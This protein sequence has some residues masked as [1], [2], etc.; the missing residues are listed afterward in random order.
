MGG[1]KLPRGGRVLAWTM[2]FVP[3]ER[4]QTTVVVPSGATASCGRYG[5]WPAVERSTGVLK[6]PPG[7]RVLAWTMLLV[8]LERYQTTVVVPSGATATWG[9][10]A[11][12]PAAVMSPIRGTAKRRHLRERRESCSIAMHS[13]LEE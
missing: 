6:L 7:G 13:T 10:V 2:V 11:F 4:Y 9:T 1:L 3:L 5:T 8:P 12:W